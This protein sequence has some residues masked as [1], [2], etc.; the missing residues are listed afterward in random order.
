MG[1]KMSA[2][3]EKLAADVRAGLTNALRDVFT[4]ASPETLHKR[5]ANT[6]ALIVGEH[7]CKMAEEHVTITK[8]QDE[9]ILEIDAEM[10]GIVSRFGDDLLDALFCE[11]RIVLTGWSVPV[12]A[13]D[14]IDDPVV[15]TTKTQRPA[16]L[17]AAKEPEKP[18]RKTRPRSRSVW[19]GD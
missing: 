7:V 10:F 11:R 1:E 15:W 8:M 4:G 9:V 13:C 5:L 3:T 19:Q 12:Q 18:T 17:P 14:S 6:L 2:A 16:S